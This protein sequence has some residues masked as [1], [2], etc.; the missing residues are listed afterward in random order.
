MTSHPR[1]LW[2]AEMIMPQTSNNVARHDEITV[3]STLLRCNKNIQLIE[4]MKFKIFLMSPAT[5]VTE[6]RIHRKLLNFI[7]SVKVIGRGRQHSTSAFYSPGD[8]R[9]K[10]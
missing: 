1:N 6:S 4:L 8:P 5:G 2:Q 10:N 7:N 9:A 3:K